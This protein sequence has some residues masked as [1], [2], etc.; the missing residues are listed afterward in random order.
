[1]ADKYPSLS[2]YNYCAWNPVNVIDPNGLDSINVTYNSESGKWDL[3]NPIIAEGDDVFI[4]TGK[5]GKPKPYSFSEGSYGDRICSLRLEDNGNQTLGV[6]LL[7]GEGVAG[8]S[9][10]PSGEPDNSAVT[11]KWDEAKPIE[12][13]TYNIGAVGGD[14]WNGWPEFSNPS[15][16]L[17]AGR[18]VAAHYAYSSK[19]KT[20]SAKKFTTKC[21]VVSSAYT[22]DGG[23]VRYNCAESKAMAQKVA[24]Y[25]GATDF[26]TRPDKY[27]QCVGINNPKTTRTV[28]STF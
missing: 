2:P 17:N 14:I 21:M 12:C 25:C 13:G 9:V 22:L 4:V 10:E 7:S 15:L 5:D 18:G 8:F 23:T 6:F 3:S 28:K 24:K 16:N 20:V 27:D 26:K 11:N 1:M 19:Y